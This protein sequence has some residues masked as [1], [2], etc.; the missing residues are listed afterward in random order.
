MSG[1]NLR[2]IAY[3]LILHIAAGLVLTGS[4]SMTS[5]PSDLG[6]TPDEERA[7]EAVT[8]DSQEVERAV[9]QLQQQDKQ[10]EQER[11]QKLQELK[12]K[13]EA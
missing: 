4:F 1:L 9:E 12:E 2:Y 5:R 8:V 6:D 7:I 3:S 11:R 10:A 13:T